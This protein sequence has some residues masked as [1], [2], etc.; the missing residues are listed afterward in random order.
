LFPDTTK[1]RLAEESCWMV[2][3]VLVAVKG[4]TV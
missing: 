3:P 1:V 4:P 2:M